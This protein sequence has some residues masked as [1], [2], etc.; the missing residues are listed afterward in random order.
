[1]PIGQPR[2]VVVTVHADWE[3]IGLTVLG[4]G[5]GAS[6]VIG[7]VRTVLSRRKR[8]MDAAAAAD[9]EGEVSD[10]DGD[11]ADSASTDGDGPDAASTP[12]DGPAR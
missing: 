10:S 1:V 3:I 4:I 12:D 2:D 6:L 8:A 11:E 5:I 9:G 7:L